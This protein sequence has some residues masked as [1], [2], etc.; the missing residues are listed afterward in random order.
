MHTGIISWRMLPRKCCAVR[1]RDDVRVS[2]GRR[3]GTSSGAMTLVRARPRPAPGVLYSEQISRQIQAF[4][5]TARH[6]PF[7]R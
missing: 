1:H 4:W 6:H 5:S 3:E 2:G 7:I